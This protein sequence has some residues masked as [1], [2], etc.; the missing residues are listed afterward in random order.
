[1][2]GL[3]ACDGPAPGTDGAGTA[4]TDST[5]SASLQPVDLAAHGLPLLLLPPDPTINDGA[6]PTIVWKDGPGVLEIKAGEH[7]GLTIAEEPGDPARL[8]AD[9][10][11]DLLQKHTVLMDSTDLVMYRS[12]FPD[13][14][15][16]VFIHFYQVV[17]AGDRQFLVQDVDGFRFN[18]ADVRTMARSIVVKPPA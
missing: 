4:A 9:L 6:Q 18:E 10:D 14:P 3:L 16:L 11:R 1:M 12:A 17:R 15:S 13:D 8:K 5:R 7:F 2:L